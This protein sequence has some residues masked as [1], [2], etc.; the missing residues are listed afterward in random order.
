MKDHRMDK[1]QLNVKLDEKVGEGVYANW[2]ML[3]FSPSEFVM[4]FGRILPGLP[5]A[6]VYSRVITTPQHAK[7]FLQNLAKTIE[8]YETQHGEI[9]I[10]GQE[11]H[12][13][14]FKNV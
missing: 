2:S 14:G 8:N 11:S 12:S 4:D 13:I 3:T 5:D 6:H 1:K 9:K 7:F 10:P